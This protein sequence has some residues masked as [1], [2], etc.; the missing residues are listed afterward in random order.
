MSK[1]EKTEINE[2]TV[3]PVGWALGG[4]AATIVILMAGQK[5][6]DKVDSR[7]YNIEEALH[8]KHPE[9]ASIISPIGSAHAGVR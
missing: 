2:Y 9:A 6:A 1:S 8:I 5:W 7:L 4:I 3:V